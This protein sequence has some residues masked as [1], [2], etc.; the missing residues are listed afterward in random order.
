MALFRIF[1]ST[2]E[3]R[4]RIAE[5]ERVLAEREQKIAELEG[6][7]H[8]LSADLEEAVRAQHRQAS[9]FRRQKRKDPKDRKKPGRKKGHA[10][11]RLVAPEPKAERETEEPKECPNGKSH[12]IGNIRRHENIEIEIPKIEPTITRNIF[13]SFDCLD[14][15]ESFQA[16]H[17]DQ[18]ST[19]IGA[20]SVHVGPQARA[21]IAELKYG[22]GLPY[23]KCVRILHDHFGIELTPGGL[24]QANAALGER[25]LPT[26]DAMIKKLG[27]SFIVHA[28]ET[29]WWSLAKAWLWVIASEELTVYR[30]SPN[31]NAT[32]VR[33]VLGKKFKGR[34]MRDGLSSYDKRLPYKMLRCLRH[35]ERNLEALEQ[36]LSGQAKEQ[37]GWLLGWVTAVWT[38]R[39]DSSAMS[40]T[41]YRKEARELVAWF[42]WFLSSEE[43]DPA[44]AKTQKGLAKVRNQIVPYVMDADLPATNN[45]AERQIRPAVIVRKISGGTRSN[46]GSDTFERLST[47]AASAAQQKR[48]LSDVFAAILRAPPGQPVPF[49]V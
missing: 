8:E 43:L 14:C 1:R 33:S 46:R 6:K 7:I 22:L 36:G 2:G 16:T 17:P 32:L 34:V 40:S 44:L 26:V 38:L 10:G 29:G 4:A 47:I 28:D 42:D 24:S 18:I 30:I 5:L 3:L 19:A 15:G 48:R 12:R 9:P 37:V 11:S 45:L 25:A 39:H 31:R 41:R 23:R 49:W 13:W 20:A 21:L 27:E 35:I